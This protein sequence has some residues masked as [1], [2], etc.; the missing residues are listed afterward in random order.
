[1]LRHG[2]IVTAFGKKVLHCGWSPLP[3]E[4]MTLWQGEKI[5]TNTVT[6]L[7]TVWLFHPTSVAHPFLKLVK[8]FPVF[9]VSSVLCIHIDWFGSPPNTKQSSLFNTLPDQLCILLFAYFC[10][11]NVS[12]HWYFIIR[13]RNIL[14]E[15]T[16][17]DSGE[18][19]RIVKV[20][21]I[22]M[23]DFCLY[24]METKIMEESTGII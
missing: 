11:I 10:Q 17:Q 4:K 9:L 21:R 19:I 5:T 14:L 16:N 18:T 8:L 12:F 6:H 3:V 1:M 15:P 13:K 24:H 20:K 22:N 23:R 2:N 7:I